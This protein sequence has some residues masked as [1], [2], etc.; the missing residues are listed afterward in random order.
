MSTSQ[1]DA[2]QLR[3]VYGRFATGIALVAAHVNGRP[4]GMLTNSFSSVSLDPPLVALSF[5]RTSTT[6]PQLRLAPQW[7]ISVL[8]QHHSEDMDRLSRPSS[9]RF[10]GL[11][12]T[13]DDKGAVLLDRAVATLDVRL[14][15]ELDG[16]DHML[17]LLRVTETHVSADEDPLVF[18]ASQRRRLA[19]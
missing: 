13:A 19:N 9:E 7:G 4:V 16:G 15:A 12:W 10:N 3:G 18:Y 11:D 2:S 8:G 1:L 5:A 17:T 14:H 6:W